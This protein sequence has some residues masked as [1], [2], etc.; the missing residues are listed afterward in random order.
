MGVGGMSGMPYA[1][2]KSH[3]K[4]LVISGNNA[5]V[6]NPFA[7]LWGGVLTLTFR[8]PVN[9]DSF[10]LIM[11]QGH[12][13][14]VD[15]YTADGKKHGLQFYGK[16][17]NSYWLVP[18]KIPNVLQLVFKPQSISGITHINFAPEPLLCPV[19][20]TLDFD[21]LKVGTLVT[22]IAEGI[23]VVATKESNG[24]KQ[25]GALV[26]DTARPGPDNLDFGA[27]HDTAGGPGWGADGRRGLPFPNLAKQGNALTVSVDPNNARPTLS[28][29]GGKMIFKFDPP[30][31][32]S[33]IGLLNNVQGVHIRAI[34]LYTG[35]YYFE[36]ITTNV[37]GR[38]SFQELVLWEG[39]T[40]ELQVT[41]NGPG[42][43]T[44]LKLGTC[45]QL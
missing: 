26:I 27:P 28:R 7:N 10:G 17:F 35:Q 1:N 23:T 31:Y 44:F 8:I 4:L 14:N 11:G 33:S 6:N 12:R 16:N 45:K 39:A 22:K 19:T 30:V 42:A 29:G 9:L 20:R 32:L 21:N 40:T 13:N 25:T 24:D 43:I 3:G 2:N 18:V 41:F 38:N 37:G 15:A 5:A 34:I 36:D